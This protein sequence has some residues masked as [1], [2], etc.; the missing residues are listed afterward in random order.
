MKLIE[1]KKK[2][3]HDLRLMSQFSG[4]EVAMYQ[5]LSEAWLPV[6]SAL[7]KRINNNI[8]DGEGNLKT[9]K[10]NPSLFDNKDIENLIITELYKK[11]DKI[12]AIL[13]GSY[14]KGQKLKTTK[15][16]FKKATKTAGLIK[17]F[18]EVTQ[19]A[20]ERVKT[21][22][23]RVSK[24]VNSYIAGS[25][26]KETGKEFFSSI[27][28]TVKSESWTFQQSSVA[29]SRAYQFG[30]IQE[31][32]IM[33]I[34]TYRIVEVM[35]DRT[36][37]VCASIH[38]TE[39]TVEFALGLIEQYV[40]S[41]DPIEA[42]KTLF[43]F[44]NIK[45]VEGKSEQALL[46]ANIALPP[47]HPLCRGVVVP[48]KTETNT[49]G[50]KFKKPKSTPNLTKDQKSAMAFARQTGKLPKNLLDKLTKAG[51]TKSEIDL[52]MA[53][54]NEGFLN[55]NIPMFLD[56]PIPYGTG[57]Q[58][59]K[60][61]LKNG[62]ITNGFQSYR[63][64]KTSG[65]LFS[66]GG[67]VDEIERVLSGNELH[68]TK[69]YKTVKEGNL[70]PLREAKKRPL[71]GRVQTG[72]EIEIPEG[73]ISFKLNPS[74]TERTTITNGKA[75]DL[76]PDTQKNKILSKNKGSLGTTK[77]NSPFVN[78]LSE[79]E[80]SNIKNVIRNTNAG[81]YT[82]FTTEKGIESQI[83]GGIDLSRGDVIEIQYPAGNQR[84]KTFA[85]K[86]SKEYNI[87]IKGI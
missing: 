26:T 52:F 44:P 27:D 11:K 42:S 33:G 83:Y 9:S 70:V 55:G 13:E 86:L 46:D 41:N 5:V 39:F 76:I 14:G 84:A 40:N 36:C 49:E 73:S 15:K 53:E 47:F 75:S 61:L 60:T 23:S 71:Y 30:S 21:L 4:E 3:N 65:F 82:G 24:K 31:F 56:F 45:D 16:S 28:K 7:M 38:G 80:N 51:L 85:T 68:K 77:N 48:G 12:I 17:I 81:N 22:G 29:T 2:I 50:G 35:D 1:T 34:T 25:P 8:I 20:I 59:H 87:P 69:T 32:Q 37:S 6:Y 78:S 64:K 57:S 74:L 18:Q 72:K 19:S 79:L 58:A 43:P 66:K 63:D 10:M 67:K 62:T 54:I